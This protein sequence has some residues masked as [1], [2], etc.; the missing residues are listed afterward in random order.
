M[1]W[2]YAWLVFGLVLLVVGASWLVKAASILAKKYGI[3][4]LALGLTLVAF[5]T[6]APELFVN[7]IAALQHHQ[8]IVLGNIIGSNNFNLFFILGLTGLI[9]PLVVQ[10]STVWKEIPLSLLSA[11]LVLLLGNSIMGMAVPSISR[12]DGIVLLLFFVVFLYYI[13]KQL[14]NEPDSISVE[15]K[16]GSNLKIGALFIFGLAGLIV[17][18]KFVTGSAIEIATTYGVSEKT[19]GLTI[20]AAGTSLP[21]LATTVIAALKGNNK[22]AVGNVVGS[23][24]FNILFILASSALI[25]PIAYSEAFN[26]DVFFLIIGTCFLFMV[27]VLNKNYTLNR[28]FSFLLMAVYIAY[29]LYLIGYSVS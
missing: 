14:K 8:D 4:D 7:T 1:I 13:N 23:N 21:E 15:I 22:I 16:A 18:S 24:I 6:S 10:K 26:L 17:G 28:L 9:T 20:V 12:V 2:L 19:I 29:I 5:G 27:L 11:L 25:N 3:S